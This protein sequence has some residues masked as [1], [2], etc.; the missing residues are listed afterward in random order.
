MI[1]IAK[2]LDKGQLIIHLIKWNEWPFTIKFYG[3]LRLPLNDGSFTMTV[4]GAMSIFWILSHPF[5]LI[6][7]FIVLINCKNDDDDVRIKLKFNACGRKIVAHKQE[8]NID[9]I[10]KLIMIACILPKFMMLHR[11]FYKVTWLDS[12]HTTYSLIFSGIR[13]SDK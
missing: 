1:S 5:K 9:N 3:R 4:E 13:F 7:N 6:F 12:L 2:H 10:L 8:D 11:T